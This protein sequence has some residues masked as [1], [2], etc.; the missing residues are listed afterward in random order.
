MFTMNRFSA[1]SLIELLIVITI[2]GVIAA[3]AVPAYKSYSHRA[4]LSQ[5]VPVTTSISDKVRIFYESHGTFPTS[6]RD[7]GIN[8][9]TTEFPEVMPPANVAGY[10]APPNVMSVI[11]SVTPAT[12]G[13]CA[14]IG[15]NV[16]VSNFD[17]TGALTA[18]NSNASY[19]YYSLL[20]IAT[21][22]NSW[23]KLCGF[24]DVSM[25]GGLSYEQGDLIPGCYNLG[26]ATGFTA[27]TNQLNTVL[28]RCP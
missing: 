17:S 16:Y 10:L 6:M 5:A 20:S 19:A 15:V 14:F 11:Y 8:S 9:S 25:I 27:F 28:A 13:S 21:P 12:P 4:V 2:I 26:T 23:E 1:F 24:T 3:I 18:S 7:I 22:N